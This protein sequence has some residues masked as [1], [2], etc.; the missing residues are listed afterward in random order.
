MWAKMSKTLCSR[1][2]KLLITIKS[3]VSQKIHRLR[4]MFLV[5]ECSKRFSKSLKGRLR[6][7][8]PKEDEN[9]HNKNL[10]RWTPRTFFLLWVERLWV[11]K[12]L[13]NDA[14]VRRNLALVLKSKERQTS[15]WVSFSPKCRSKTF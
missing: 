6:V 5:K 2:C 3:R 7:F 15:D 1:F 14:L 4:E 12:I 9:I 8:L 11:S 13:L 10:F